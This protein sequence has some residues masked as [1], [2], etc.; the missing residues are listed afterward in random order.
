MRAKSN[1]NSNQVIEP[2]RP[3]HLQYSRGS[4]SKDRNEPAKPPES[5]SRS[6]GQTLI[7]R[8]FGE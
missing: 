1:L 6:R 4:E 5:G 3:D 8:Y 2:A 7:N